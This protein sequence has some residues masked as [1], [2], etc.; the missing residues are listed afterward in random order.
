MSRAIAIFRK[1]VRHLWV[2]IL[3]YVG[4]LVLFA[5]EDPAYVKHDSTTRDLST[6]LY[7]LLPLACWLLVTSLMQGEKTV[8]DNQYWL[9]RPFSRI[10]LLVAKALFLLLFLIAPV[11]VCQL[12]VLAENDFS[13]GHYFGAMLIKQVFFLAWLL[14]PMAA[15]ATVTRNLGHAFLDGLVLGVAIFL[16]YIVLA[17]AGRAGWGEL[18]WI[19]ATGVAA[20]S[21]CASGAVVFVQY[22]RRRTALSFAISAAGAAIC[23]LAWFVPPW[24]PAFTI[25]SWFST[26]K[27]GPDAVRISWDSERALTRTAL[28]VSPGGF[29]IHVPIRL[30]N[31]P[32]GLNIDEV[33]ELT[34]SPWRSIWLGLAPSAEELHRGELLLQVPR[35]DYERLQNVPIHVRGS[36]DLTL[37]ANEARNPDCW[38]DAGY[39]PYP[40]SPWFGPIGKCLDDDIAP[41]RVPVAYIQRSFDLGPL[42]LPG[43]VVP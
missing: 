28:N 36:L 33:G 21:L 9:T 41:Q 29:L 11:F 3:V 24:Q 13:P 40:I 30:E 43:G 31:L 17:G 25:Q 10:D 16:S 23:L 20:I 42:R 4:T 27:I 12:V 8:G 39:A 22:T 15:V 1:D 26:R 38:I 19:L 32:A 6:F 34:E 18:E 5:C 7:I 37:S 35:R 14:L 2:Q